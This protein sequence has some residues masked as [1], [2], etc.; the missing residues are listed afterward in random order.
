MDH[1]DIFLTLQVRLGVDWRH[2]LRVFS[3]D[4]VGIGDVLA[5]TWRGYSL[6]R[7]PF[8]PISPNRMGY[9]RGGRRR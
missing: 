1:A 7:L 3:E 5:V 6:G 8:V 4:G 9:P 2:N